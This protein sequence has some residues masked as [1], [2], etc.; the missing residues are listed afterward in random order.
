MQLTQASFIESLY[1]SNII[2]KS[3]QLILQL[4]SIYLKYFFSFTNLIKEN[5]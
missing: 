5:G 4:F 2:N 1:I 3:F